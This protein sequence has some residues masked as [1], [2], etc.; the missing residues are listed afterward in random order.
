VGKIRDQVVYWQLGNP[1]ATVEDCEAWLRDAAKRGEFGD[2]T[3]VAK[4]TNDGT[5]WRR[6]KKAVEKQD[7]PPPTTDVGE[8]SNT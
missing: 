3:E 1:S 2:L 7:N 8:S 5:G 6:K 4:S